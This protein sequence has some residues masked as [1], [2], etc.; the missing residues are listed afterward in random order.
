MFS[1]PINNY[2]LICWTCPYVCKYV[3]KTVC[4][5]KEG[6]ITIY[7]PEV[8]LQGVTPHMLTPSRLNRIPQLKIEITNIIITDGWKNKSQT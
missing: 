8:P 2:I 5:M 6:A 3:Y 1:I 7:I 4:C